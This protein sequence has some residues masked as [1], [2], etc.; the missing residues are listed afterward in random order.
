MEI[1][2][3]YC[4]NLRSLI[5]ALPIES[6]GWLLAPGPSGAC[7]NDSSIVIMTKLLTILV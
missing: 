1:L 7:G 4:L 5:A 6:Q 2:Q 3:A